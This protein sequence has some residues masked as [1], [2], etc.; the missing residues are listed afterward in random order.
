MVAIR[1]L[2]ADKRNHCIS[3]F[4]LDGK[5]RGERSVPKGSD[6]GEL[7]CPAGVAV[8]EYGCILVIEGVNH[9]VSIFDKDG[10]FVHCFGSKGFAEGQFHTNES[11]GIALSPDGNIYISDYYNKRIQ[12]YSNF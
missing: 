6:K 5:L 8:D 2:V 7:Y 4:T 3:F 1:L 11:L 10:V 9:R 12:I